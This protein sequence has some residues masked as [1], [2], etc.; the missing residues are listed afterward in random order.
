MP[1]TILTKSPSLLCLPSVYT[2]G[3]SNITNTQDDQEDLFGDSPEEIDP[4]ILQ[5]ILGKDREQE[6]EDEGPA[7]APQGHN[8]VSS[9]RAG[10]KRQKPSALWKRAKQQ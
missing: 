2:S 9:C 6:A 7:P 1:H 8:P 10:H 3:H 4:E 5:E